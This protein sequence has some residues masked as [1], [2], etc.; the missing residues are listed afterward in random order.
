MI[1]VVVLV[2]IKKQGTRSFYILSKL[3][4]P[5]FDFLDKPKQVRI[6]LFLAQSKSLKLFQ[7]LA[8]AFFKK[9]IKEL[10]NLCHVGKISPKHVSKPPN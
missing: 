6:L 8:L 7:E 3:C 10:V 5:E 1:L 4:S 2:L 9:L